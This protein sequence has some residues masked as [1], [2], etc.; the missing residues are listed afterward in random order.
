MAGFVQSEDAIIGATVVLLRSEG[1][2]EAKEL[3]RNDASVGGEGWLWECSRTRSSTAVL[4]W[5][6]RGHKWC[7]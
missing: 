7:G 4:P 6:E 1:L 5:C 2:F 3:L